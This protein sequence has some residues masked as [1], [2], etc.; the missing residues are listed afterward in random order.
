MNLVGINESVGGSIKES[1]GGSTQESW[2]AHSSR[3]WLEWG[4]SPPALYLAWRPLPLLCRNWRGAL[5][6][7]FL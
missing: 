4:T 6:V 1:V 5:R 3:V 7:Y 2:V